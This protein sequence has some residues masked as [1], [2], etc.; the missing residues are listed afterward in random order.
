M[1]DV[2]VSI[3]IPERLLSVLQKLVENGYYM[4]VSEVLRSIVRER[5]MYSKHPELEELR[6]LRED[7]KK[8]VTKKTEKIVMQQVMEELNKIK[9]L[10]KDE[11]LLK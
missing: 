11:G 9:D 3:R 7:I 8:G 2:I 4:D 10:V 1:N 5:W 6:K